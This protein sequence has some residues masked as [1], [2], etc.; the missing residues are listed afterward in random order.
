MRATAGVV[1]AATAAALA[2]ACSSADEE[3]ALTVGAGDS[4]QSQVIA[5]IYAQALTRT[6]THTVTREHLGQ[7]ADYL[8]ALD[9]GTVTVVGDTSGDLLRVFDSSSRASAPDQAIAAKIAEG[10]TASRPST[11]ATSPGTAAANR[12][13]SVAEDLSRAVPEGLVVSDLADATDLRP[14]LALAPSAATHFP[15]DASALAPH[16]AELSVGI[17][18]GRELDPLRTAPDPQRDVLTPLHEVYGCDI[19]RHTVFSN[20]SE[21]RKA[22]QDGQIDAGVFTSA[23]ALLPGGPGDLAVVADPDYAFRAQNV[24]P[25]LRQGALDQ[26]QIKKLNYVAGELTAADFADLIRRV[27]DGHESVSDVAR[28]WLDEHNL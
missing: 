27:R 14:Q 9:A 12:V 20:D 19:V 22:L 11:E 24:I 2:V 25:L 23:V 5:Q 6:G 18:T 3:P 15:V 4:V 17:A 8:A 13:D 26:Q 21:L 7:R 16:C 10:R 1:I 28:G